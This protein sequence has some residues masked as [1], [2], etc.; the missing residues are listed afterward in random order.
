[1]I[2]PTLSRRKAVARAPE[3]RTWGHQAWLP[4]EPNFI[5][6]QGLVGRSSLA[7]WG[8]TSRKILSAGGLS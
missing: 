3:P 8:G 6:A 2:C 4:E 5:W 1:M 7:L